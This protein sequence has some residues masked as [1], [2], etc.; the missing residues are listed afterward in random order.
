MISGSV[1][2]VLVGESGNESEYAYLKV[3]EFKT[4]EI[5]MTDS[6][7]ASSKQT[8]PLVLVDQIRV[9]NASPIFDEVMSSMLGI[10]VVLNEELEIVALN[11]AFLNELGVYDAESSLGLKLGKTIGC[12]NA[13]KA[14]EGCGTTETCKTCG[15]VIAMMT[16]LK[17][18]EKDEQICALTA[19]NNGRTQHSSLLVRTCPI[20][21]EGQRFI[22]LTAKDVT[23]EQVRANL[24]RVFYHDISNMITVLLGG[25]DLLAQEMPSR[26]EVVQAHEAA[27]RLQKEI[28]LQ[29]EL[30]LSSSS[31]NFI[32]ERYQ[33]ELSAINKDIEL[34]MRGH[35]AARGRTIEVVQECDD[36]LIYTDKHM[37]SRVLA[38][39]L[40]NALEATLRGGVVKYTVRKEGGNICWEVWNN[41]SIPIDVQARV[42]QR[43]FS[44]KGND[45]RGLGT[46]SM[47]LFGETYL[48]GRVNFSSSEKDG[49]VF[50]FCLPLQI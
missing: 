8:D 2:T 35:I 1:L 5:S 4:L 25:C 16:A 3:F 21:I 17:R 49:T 34:L 23:Q 40:I 10:L 11:D 22:I 7:L 32:P 44:T 33:V 24:E 15:A 46:F 31:E 27:T 28:A 47:K 19:S 6:F 13:Q 38:N 45:G 12:V 20:A 30:S 18:G 48:Q 41:T 36:C 39:M 26:W 29:R 37:V 43:H 14:E 50:L 9:V 42:F